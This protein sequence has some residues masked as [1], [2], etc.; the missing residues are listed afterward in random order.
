MG[1]WL[2]SGAQDF[3]REAGDTQKFHTS[4]SCSQSKILLLPF[5]NSKKMI[6]TKKIKKKIPDESATF[7]GEGSLGSTCA[8]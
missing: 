2:G 6:N 3:L 7:S 4:R 8:S 5:E 1:K